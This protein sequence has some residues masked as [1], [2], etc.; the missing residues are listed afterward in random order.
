MD[1]RLVSRDMFLLN[2]KFL[3]LRKDNTGDRFVRKSCY[4]KYDIEAIQLIVVAVVGDVG[5]D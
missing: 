4:K 3:I 2:N 5:Q 1:E